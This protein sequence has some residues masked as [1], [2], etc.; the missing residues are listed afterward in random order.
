[1]DLKCKKANIAALVLQGTKEKPIY[2]V[3]FANVNVDEVGVGLSFSNTE[4]VGIANC[5]L[6]GYIG[7]P[8]TVS[9]KDNIFKK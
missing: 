8:S 7:I 3:N 4:I 9:S 1:M 6:G 2:N 5:N